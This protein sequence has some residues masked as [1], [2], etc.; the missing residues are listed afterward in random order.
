VEQKTKMKWLIISTVIAIIAIWLP[1]FARSMFQKGVMTQ[2]LSVTLVMFSMPVAFFSVVTA[3]SFLIY[4]L[5][6]KK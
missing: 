5:A 6:K 2:N 1:S 4:L 3:V